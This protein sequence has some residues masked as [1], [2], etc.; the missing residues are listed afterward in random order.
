[1][2]TTASF[3]ALRPSAPR[4]TG[5]QDIPDAQGVDTAA[6]EVRVEVEA[7]TDNSTQ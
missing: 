5:Y 4:S 3:E 2:Q 1:M 7:T 6:R